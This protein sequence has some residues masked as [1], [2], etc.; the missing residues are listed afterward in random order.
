MAVW[1]LADYNPQVAELLADDRLN[2]LGPGEPVVAL[3][4]RLRK[5][6]PENLLAPRPV[7]D[8]A[9]ASAALA[10][11][12][13]RADY[14]DPAH[15]ISQ[16]LETV[17][18]SYWHALVHRREPDYENS[19]YWF[20]RVGTHPIF[21]E[22]TVEA[23]RVAEESKDATVAKKMLAEVLERGGA[24]DPFRFVDLCRRV[25]AGA[26]AGGDLFC[27]LAQKREWELLFAHCVAHA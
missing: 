14:L 21:S 1:N 16:S 18:G 5:L 17:E 9:M 26:E 6:T 11:L 25:S 20:R 23:E 27:R 8:R 10:G 13:L 22:L 2:E 24:W 3:E 7:L 4:P 19:K 15:E 12:W